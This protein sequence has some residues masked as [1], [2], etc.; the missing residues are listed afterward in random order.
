MPMTPPVA[1]PAASRPTQ[2]S[3]GGVAPLGARRAAARPP[4]EPPVEEWGRATYV[5]PPSTAPV[6]DLTI[7]TPPVVDLGP[8][9]PAPPKEPESVYEAPVVPPGP[10]TPPAAPPVTEARATQAPPAFG[11]PAAAEAPPT[12][13]A[14]SGGGE[15]PHTAEAPP[16]EDPPMPTRVP[17]QHLSHHPLVTGD[18]T[19]VSADPMRPYRVHEL[20]T[21]HAQGKRRG[22]E[23]ADGPGVAETADTS[24]GHV[25]EDGR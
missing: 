7:V 4:D 12:W 11:A 24:Q 14:P 17:G 21:R 25:Q 9:V 10:F 20:L 8:V 3:D 23:G 6:D 2:P 19:D 22:Q 18:A 16:I 13:T 5:D 1:P 15:Q